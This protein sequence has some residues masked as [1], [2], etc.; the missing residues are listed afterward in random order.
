[1]SETPDTI[2][3]KCNQRT[4]AI[5]ATYLVDNDVPFRHERLMFDIHQL[6]FSAEDKHH[7]DFLQVLCRMKIEVVTI[8]AARPAE[9]ELTGKLKKQMEEALLAAL[10]YVTDVI[11]SPEQLACF[12]RGSVQAHER[13]IRAALAAAGVQ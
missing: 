6:A 13:Q 1:M 10:P 5:I 7:V 3:I 2:A 11:E 8:E 4:A 12:V 9:P